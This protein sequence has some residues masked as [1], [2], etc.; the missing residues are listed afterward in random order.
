[1]PTLIRGTIKHIRYLEAR[2]SEQHR[3]NRRS[4][5]VRNN[6]TDR[7]LN[8]RLEHHNT[9]NSTSTFVIVIAWSLIPLH[10]NS[11]SFSRSTTWKSLCRPLRSYTI[12]F[13]VSRVLLITSSISR[14]VSEPN[15]WLR[16]ASLRASLYWLLRCAV[17]CS[18]AAASSAATFFSCATL[19]WA[20]LWAGGV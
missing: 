14:C 11:S 20:A 12:C 3:R 5:K 19:S 15:V 13:F 9:Q 18:C 10:S 2:P 16:L 17:C 4:H 7:S 6:I 1:M 8:K